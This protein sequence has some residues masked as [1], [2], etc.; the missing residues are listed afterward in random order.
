VRSKQTDLWELLRSQRLDVLALQETLLRATDWDL[1]VRDYL[2]FS[3]L[4]HTAASQRGVSILVARSL[5]S[6][7]VGPSSPFWVFVRVSGTAHPTPIVLGSVYLPH[8]DAGRSIR[9]RLAEALV[10]IHTECPD[11]AIVLMGDLNED[12]EGAQRLAQAWPGTFD[13][14][15]NQGRVPTTRRTGGRTID[16]ICL[17]GNGHLP[18]TVSPP[19][20]LRDWDI[21]DHF[22]VVARIPP[23]RTLAERAERGTPAEVQDVP[24]TPRIRTPEF[25][26]RDSIIDA[27][28]WEA[29][30]D[31]AAAADA[32]LDADAAQAALAALSGRLIACCHN[33]AAGL[34]LVQTP[35]REGPS[36]VPRRLSRVIR[37]RRKAFRRLRRAEANPSVPE[38]ALTGFQVSHREAAK[39][40]TTAT[41]QFRRKLWHKRVSQAHADLLRSPRQF[42]RWASFTARWNLKSASSGIQP[43]R[44]RAGVLQTTLSGQLEV[45]RDHYATLASDSTGNSQRPEKWIAI[46]EDD[47]LPPLPGLDHDFNRSEVWTALERMKTHRSPGADGIPTDFLRACL[48]ERVRHKAWLASNPRPDQPEP[49]THMTSA[50]LGIAQRSWKT[51]TIPP[52]WMDSVVVSL[53]KKGDLTD[54]NN[55]RGISLMSTTLKILCVILVDRINTSAEAAR[56]FSPS[57][58]G[59]RRLEEAVTQAACLVEA[60]KRRRLAHLPTLGLFIDLKKAYDMVP[61]EGLFAKLRR[62]GIRGRCLTFIRGLYGRSTIRVRLGH[63]SGAAFT[64]PFALLRGVR[65]GCPLSCVL[66]NVFIN[67]LFD[68]LPYGGVEIPSGGPGTLSIPGLLFADDAL[69]L[70][71]TLPALGELCDHITAWSADNEMQVGIQKCGLM[72]FGANGAGGDSDTDVLT[73]AGLC[74]SGVPVPVV[75]E[76]LYLG[77]TVTRSLETAALVKPRLESGR[78]TVYS[79]APFLRCPVIPLSSRLQVIRGVV[80]PRLLY[81]AEIYGMNRSL[82]DVMQ[83]HLNSALRSLIR[84]ESWRGL[85]SYGLWKEFGLKPICALAAGRRIRAFL[86]CSALS[87]WVS[88]LVAHPYATRKWTWVTGVGRWTMRWCPQ[89]SHMPKEEWRDWQEWSPKEAKTH[90]EDAICHREFEIRRVGYRKRPETDWYVQGQYD[91]SPLHRPHTAYVPRLN[92]GIAL[93]VR[94]RLGAF[95]TAEQLLSWGKLP[96]EWSDRCPCCRARTTE[97]IPHILLECRRW[98]PHRDKYLQTLLNDSA[99]LDMDP[100]L[101]LCRNKRASLLLG[102]SIGDLRLPHWM[103]TCTRRDDAASDASSASTSSTTDLSETSS[104]ASSYLD[105]AEHPTLGTLSTPAT[106]CLQV[107][108][109]LL[110]VVRARSLHLG[111]IPDWPVSHVDRSFSA[112]GQRPAG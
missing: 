17:F 48:E 47:R 57:Q 31:D 24:P 8:Q 22:P 69:G 98:E 92:P 61:H 37:R 93:I 64:E 106:G 46:A 73:D 30:A 41:K 89:H 104:E 59:F 80:L 102:G 20:V 45:W 42:W 52:E 6:Q 32:E 40:A 4:G 112:P 36:S 103:P 74:L 84:T 34:D 63:G 5:N 94:F 101:T 82:T 15:A 54:P 19:H 109:F 71:P 100:E 78:K 21:S 12:L 111:T 97:D 38:D 86:K 51:G 99:E 56:R 62:F 49:P 79:L 96:P 58:A 25:H 44:N 33:V 108:S 27:N 14:L 91:Q 11:S 70:A 105:I 28:P 90:V 3:A 60:L 23:L 72:E 9:R 10:Q 43:V 81:G 110:L 68:N 76:Y 53:A 13:V 107:A 75:E 65:Q 7:V 2:C 85:P 18:G 26:Q 88:R 95:P 83:R 50:I 1:S 29:L 39:A 35:P 77:V 67:D 16:H 66:F 55:Y 87:T